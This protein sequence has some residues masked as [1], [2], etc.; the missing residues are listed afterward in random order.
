MLILIPGITGNIGQHLAR[1]ALAREHEVRGLGRSSDKLDRKIWKN[2]ESFVQ[3]QSYY[4][5]AA[6]DRACVGIDAVVVAYSGK[7]ELQLDGQLILLRAAERAGVK[8]DVVLSK[9]FRFNR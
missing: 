1:E 7:P 2:I 9:A 6:I 3:V 8:V 5:I 4:D